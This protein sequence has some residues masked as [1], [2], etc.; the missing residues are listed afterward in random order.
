MSNLPADSQKAFQVLCHVLGRRRLDRTRSRTRCIPICPT[1]YTYSSLFLIAKSCEPRLFKRSLKKQKCA[2]GVS[3]FGV[4]LISYSKCYRSFLTKH[5]GSQ[6]STYNCANCRH[7]ING[8]LLISFSL[9]FSL[10]IVWRIARSRID[11]ASHQRLHYRPQ[12]CTF[13]MES[14]ICRIRIGQI[15]ASLFHLF[16]FLMIIFNCGVQR[17]CGEIGAVHLDGR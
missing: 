12:V 8:L 9:S 3:S 7:K 16:L 1:E 10:C 15:Q 14:Q 13:L 5:A 11:T 4:F 6:F 17:V 2:T